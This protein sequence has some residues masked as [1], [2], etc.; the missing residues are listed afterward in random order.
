MHPEKIVVRNYNPQADYEWVKSLYLLRDT[1]WGQY[2]DARDAAEKL[3][4]LSTK[5]P[6]KILVATVD[7]MIVWTVT[8]FEDGRAARLYRF[9]VQRQDEDIITK[10]LSLVATNILKNM[11]HTQVLV[12]APSE[13]LHFE[14][15]YKKL[16]FVKWNDYTAYWKDI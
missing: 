6:D 1:F 2:D 10:E 3:L 12:Y 16:W 14:D 5:Y 9:A 8:L 13:D 15:R 4:Q 7:N 11:W